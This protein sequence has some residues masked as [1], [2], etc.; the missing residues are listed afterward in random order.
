L[1][2]DGTASPVGLCG[3]YGDLYWDTDAPLFD[4]SDLEAWDSMPVDDPKNR[5]R[6]YDN[7]H[8][9]DCSNDVN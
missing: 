4:I 1:L 6:E 8:F 5:T 9:T 2:R 3:I 7:I